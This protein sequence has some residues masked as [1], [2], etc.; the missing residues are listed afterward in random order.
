MRLTS[1]VP[2][3]VATPA[4]SPTLDQAVMHLDWAHE[5]AGTA[6]SDPD[7]LSIE[8]LLSASDDADVAAKLLTEIQQ[9]LAAEHARD[10]A[11]SLSKAA[12]AKR[13][14]DPQV[15]HDVIEARGEDAEDAIHDAFMA[16]G[17]DGRGE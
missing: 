15:A 5:A 14:E 1:L 8:E 10:A 6:V 4:P 11:I 3:A 17:M 2:A 16:L 7:Y 9:P 12:L 13:D